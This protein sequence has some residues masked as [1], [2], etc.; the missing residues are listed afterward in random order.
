MVKC[1]LKFLL[2]YFMCKYITLIVSMAHATICSNE[3]ILKVRDIGS[4]YTIHCDV[5]EPLGTIFQN[6]NKHCKQ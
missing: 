6:N 1:L 5:L 3:S 4:V 2:V